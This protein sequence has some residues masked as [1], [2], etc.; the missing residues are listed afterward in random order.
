A[1]ITIRL[2]RGEG[3]QIAKLQDE[4]RAIDSMFSQMRGMLDAIPQP[5]WLRDSAGRLLWVN[6][7]YARAVDARTGKEAL[8]RQI[9]LLDSGNR[10]MIREE[11]ERRGQFRGA[12][13]G[14]V[15]GERRR[16]DIV[17]VRGEQGGGGFAL[18]I[19]DLELAREALTRQMD[20]HVRTLD[21][22][23]TAVVM[24]DPRQQLTYSN[25]AFRDLFAL[26]AAWLATLPT[27][28]E[29]LDR[30]RLNGRL[31]EATDY[32]AWK[33]ELLAQF[34]SAESVTHAWTLPNGRALRVVISPNPQGGVTYLFEDETERFTLAASYDRLKDAQWETLMALS[35]GVAVFGSDGCLQLSNPAFARLW[36]MPPE[37]LQGNPH[38]EEVARGSEAGLARLWHE[39]ATQVCSLA[40]AR[41]EQHAEVVTADGRTLIVTITPLPDRATLVAASDITDT[42]EAEKRLREHNQALE[43]AARLRTQFIRSVSFELRSPLQVVVGNAQALAGGVFG[44]LSD[45][46]Q[47]Y[48]QTLAQAA[49][50]VLAL[51]DDILDLASVEERSIELA[52]EPVD[53]ARAIQDAM[54]GLKDRLGE[55]K[56]RVALNIA[57]GMPA[58]IA[59]PKRMTH[60][61]FNLIANAV[62]YSATGDTVRLA[63]RREGEKTLIEVSDSGRVPGLGD[64]AGQPGI[65]RQNALRFSMAR[66]LVQLHHGS[67]TFGD[68]PRGGQV[69]TVILPDL[70]PVAAQSGRLSA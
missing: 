14:V 12:I 52:L 36:R 26:D 4:Y 70:G 50:A 39:I 8:D 57:N 32:K 53:M 42:V 10:A 30:L 64:M 67:I 11:T 33:T 15:A 20:A 2:M 66:A 25:K 45:R 63:V 9:E 62:S 38:I 19:T 44:P 37:A 7:A 3:L 61:L 41:S 48:A 29:I 59:D 13:T 56:V 18:D 6:A 22:L 49:D 43:D 47:G 31:P 24:F 34:T 58:I 1:V 27:N 60:I 65:D 17:E 21:E 51:T 68:D 40:D 55:A 35:E 54:E 5:A 16:L 23:P 28:G 69:T 46:Q